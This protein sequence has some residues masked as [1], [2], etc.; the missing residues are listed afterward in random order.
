MH[1]GLNYGCHDYS[2]WSKTLTVMVNG[3]MK[4]T[5][6]HVSKQ[7]ILNARQW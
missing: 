7:D 5:G 1:V 2:T 4:K 3:W 6:V